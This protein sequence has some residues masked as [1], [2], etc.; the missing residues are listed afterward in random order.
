VGNPLAE[1][2]GGSPEPF[3][4]TLP[5]FYISPITP[6]IHVHQ[7]EGNLMTQPSNLP[8]Q[9]STI[10]DYARSDQGIREIAFRQ[11]VILICILAYFLLFFSQFAIPQEFRIILSIPFLVIAVVATVF[12]FLLATKIYSTGLGIFLGILTLIP[13]IGLIPLLIVNAKA[14]ALLRAAGLTVGLL[15]AKVPG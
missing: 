12:V 8:P 5:P 4:V 2:P 14:T 10:L 7:T 13:C 6:I 11:R 1:I 9:Q 3:D 15:G